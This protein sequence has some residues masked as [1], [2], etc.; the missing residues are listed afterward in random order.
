MY[1]VV[2]L[3]INLDSNQLS[4]SVVQVYES[5]QAAHKAAL[6]LNQAVVKEQDNKAVGFQ[7]QKD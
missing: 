2:R 6:R 3:Q 1:K 4:E 5:L 7:V